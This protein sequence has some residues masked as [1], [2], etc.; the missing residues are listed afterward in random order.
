MFSKKLQNSEISL[1]QKWVVW[2]I[3]LPN[4]SWTISD[5]DILMFAVEPASELYQAA[6]VTIWELNTTA[7]N[8]VS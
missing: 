4:S 3:I 8:R 2:S 5:V 7:N 1:R 6:L